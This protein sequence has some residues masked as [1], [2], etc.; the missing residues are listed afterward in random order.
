M[1]GFDDLLDIEC[2]RKRGIKDDLKS[3]ELS[4]TVDKVMIKTQ[5]VV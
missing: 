1:T 2:G 4:L 5:K 3:E